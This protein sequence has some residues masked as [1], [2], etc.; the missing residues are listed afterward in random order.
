MS[1][2]DKPP[3]A[4]VWAGRRLDGLR[5]RKAAKLRDWEADNC[6]RMNAIG[7]GRVQGSQPG[8][9]ANHISSFLQFDMTMLWLCDWR[10]Y[11]PRDM[12]ARCP[13]VGIRG[14]KRFGVRI[15]IWEGFPNRKV[16]FLRR[17]YGAIHHNQCL[18]C[19]SCSWRKM[20]NSLHA[21]AGTRSAMQ[22]RRRLDAAYPYA[23]QSMRPLGDP[24]LGRRTGGSEQGSIASP[25]AALAS[26]HVGEANGRATR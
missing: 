12:E 22:E 11:F 6:R 24:A 7:P 8:S 15:N 4:F 9:S 21:A 23:S 2:K 17:P 20:A 13:V 26:A 25:R 14:R 1:P 10:I 16:P 5:L 3:Q 19:D 18:T